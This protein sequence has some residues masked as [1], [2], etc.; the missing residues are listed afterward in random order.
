MLSIMAFFIFAGVTGLDGGSP[1]WPKVPL[2]Q[3]KS[4]DNP[5]VFFDISIGG[6]P[7][8]KITMELFQNIVPKTAENFRCLCTGE[9]GQG[10]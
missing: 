8:G 2:E 6:K 5:R 4:P 7:A 10:R 1:N 9:K 3:A